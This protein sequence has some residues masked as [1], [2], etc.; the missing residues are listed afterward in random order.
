MGLAL[1]LPPVAVVA[2]ER[3]LVALLVELVPEPEA[4]EPE[5]VP[6]RVAGSV[7]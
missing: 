7:P 5:Q 1:G 3:V 4:V 6:A 2:A